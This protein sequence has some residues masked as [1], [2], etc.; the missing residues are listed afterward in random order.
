M[1][2]ASSINLD[3]QGQEGVAHGVVMRFKDVPIFYTPY[4][5]FPL[6]DE[7]K[8]GLL[9][10][11]FGHSGNNGFELEVPYYFNLAPNYDL[12]L[13]PG[14]LSSRGVQV[15][16]Q[17]RYL[18][19]ASHGRIDAT[20]LPNDKIEHGDRSYLRY[21]D[22]TD[23]RE[24]LRFDADIAAV[25]DSNYFLDFA[26]GSDQTSVTYLE[27]RAD[28]LYYDD[29]WRI[30]GQLQNFQTIDT[31]VTSADRPYSRVPRIQAQGLYPILNSN[32]EFALDG[33]AVN[34]L[35]DLGPTGVRLDLSRRFAGRPAGR[36]TSS[37][38]PSAIT[39]PSTIFRMRP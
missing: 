19:A 10:P 8:S 5:S 20:F 12:T 37:N 36:D 29:A 14:L 6:G 35:R 1:L 28:V 11:S 27:R 15:A 4:I 31:S 24:G 23:F 39:S 21:I 38:P 33:E 18:T 3:T 13:T 2:Q 32:F 26:V 22:T 7:R 17:F 9:F 25:S 30:R 34:F 16:A